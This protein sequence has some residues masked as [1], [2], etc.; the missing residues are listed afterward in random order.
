MKAE[1]LRRL[2]VLLE[3][4]YPT[5]ATRH[6][7]D[8]KSCFGAVALYVDGNIFVSCGRFGVALRLPPKTLAELFKEAEVSPL[9]YFP[10]GHV[11]KEYAVIPERIIG[12]QTRL[13]SLLVKSVRY[14]SSA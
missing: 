2:E 9:K 1:Y 4:A 10:N 11:K 7:I 5:L 3:V 6:R 8:F 14:A 12:D 13:K